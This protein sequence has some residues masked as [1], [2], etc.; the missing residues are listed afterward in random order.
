MICT[1]DMLRGGGVCVECT[2]YYLQKKVGNVDKTK[3]L[4]FA[5]TLIFSLLEHQGQHHI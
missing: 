4:L 2:M 1:K 5:S 3:L